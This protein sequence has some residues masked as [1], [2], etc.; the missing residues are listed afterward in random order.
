MPFEQFLA[1]R[2]FAPLGMVEADFWVP[3]DK[4]HRLVPW[5][6]TNGTSTRGPAFKMPDSEF[7][8]NGYLTPG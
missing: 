4:A 3:P 6:Y 5:V 8:M 1:A 2:M 7:F